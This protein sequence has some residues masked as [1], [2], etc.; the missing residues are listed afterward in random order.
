MPRC[1]SRWTRRVSWIVVWCAMVAVGCSRPDPM[2]PGAP[3]RPDHKHSH[4]TSGPHGGVLAEWGDHDYHVEFTVDHQARE[5]V[6]YL[7]D[8]TAKKAP[9][10][11]PQLVTDMKVTLQNVP[12]PI[13]IELKY[14]AGRSSTQGLA[15]AG[16]HD[17]LAKEMDF[18]GEVSGL[19]KGTPYVGAFAE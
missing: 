6:V 11:D 3:K 1:T 15:F 9:A 7:L 12:G 16:R 4:G 17:I 10:L 13:V 14:D 8:A 5:V 19:V 2:P 18:R